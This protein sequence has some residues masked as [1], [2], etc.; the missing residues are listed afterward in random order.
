MGLFTLHNCCVSWSLTFLKLKPDSHSRLTIPE[1]FGYH[2]SINLPFFKNKC[3]FSLK[4]DYNKALH[5]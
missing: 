4:L 2:C 5:F 1:F 3:K